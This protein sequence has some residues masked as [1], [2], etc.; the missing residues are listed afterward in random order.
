MIY[1]LPYYGIVLKYSNP[2]LPAHSLY[3]VV[4]FFEFEIPSHLLDENLNLFLSVIF[5]FRTFAFFLFIKAR[6]KLL[7]FTQ[8][9]LKI[10]IVI[11]SKNLILSNINSI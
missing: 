11:F 8:A 5:H 4:K 10:F 3:T 1:Y 6:K 7:E 9:L 2:I